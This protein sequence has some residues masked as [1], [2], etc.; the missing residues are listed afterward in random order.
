M[1]KLAHRESQH[2]VPLAI[3]GDNTK[4]AESNALLSTSDIQVPPTINHDMY[5]QIARNSTIPQA[6]IDGI[7]D[8]L[9]SSSNAIITTPV[10]G[11]A[12]MVKSKSHPCRPHLVQVYQNGKAVC[13]E[14]CPM[15]TSLKICSH[16]VAV[17]HCLDCTN[18]FNAWFI[19]YSKKLNRTKL[20]TSSVKPNVGKKPSQN[21]YSQRK[22]NHQFYHI[23]YILHFHQCHPYIPLAM[24]L[25]LKNHVLHHLL[26][27]LAI[28]NSLLIRI[29]AIHIFVHLG[30]FI[31][32][33]VLRCQILV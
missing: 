1:K 32:L 12:R 6:T 27:H 25:L 2:P 7:L 17:V 33:G 14:N 24:L 29:G 4:K 11:V 8:E 30:V 13:D 3:G 26:C 10:E 22:A 5:S 9:L 23:L 31:H 28:N 15:W 19:S 20:S 16:C 18:D 21:H